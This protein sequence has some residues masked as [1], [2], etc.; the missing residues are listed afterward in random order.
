MAES[1]LPSPPPPKTMA[2][3]SSLTGST[4]EE[5]SSSDVT[6]PGE[7][8][9][10]VEKNLDELIAS[11]HVCNYFCGQLKHHLGNKNICGP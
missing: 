2:L 5:L 6:F 4:L 10:L 9:S 3:V 7:I 1:S 11:E 8:C